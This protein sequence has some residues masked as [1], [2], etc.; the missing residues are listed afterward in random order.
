V[1]KALMGGKM[2]ERQI[3]ALE[4]ELK[5]LYENLSSRLNQPDDSTA[6]VAPDKAIGRLTR[7]DAMQAQQMSL[8]LRRRQK[9]QL[10]QV[11]QALKRIGDGTYGLCLRCEE[12]IGAARLK[13]R[14]EAGLCLRCADRRP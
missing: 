10:Q 13:A 5:T 7:Q 6:P 1:V 2:N 14:P 12:E 9:Q 4:Q 11:E 8:E 3:N